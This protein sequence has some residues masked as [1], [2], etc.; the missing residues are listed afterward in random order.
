MS[1]GDFFKPTTAL[2]DPDALEQLK[3][4]ALEQL[5]AVG[6]GYPLRDYEPWMNVATRRPTN[7]VELP[8]NI[9]LQ[10]WKC[11]DRDA[12]R[13]EF[14]IHC[15]GG[16]TIQLHID[17]PTGLARAPTPREVIEELQK[18]LVCQLAL[19]ALKED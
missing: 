5:K 15:A 1:I 4:G 6:S 9:R 7:I 16:E 18:Q 17:T 19:V 11:A 14:T 8:A 2:G 10:T 12:T 13:S 3:A